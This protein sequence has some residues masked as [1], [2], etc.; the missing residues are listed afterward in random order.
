MKLSLFTIGLILSSS[1]FAQKNQGVVIY[2]RKQNMHRSVIEE[3]RAMIP[4]FRS[5]KHML[6][7]TEQHSLYKI[8]PK[9]EAPDPFNNRSGMAINLGGGTSETYLNFG[10][11]KKLTATDLFGNAYLI[12]DTIRKYDWKL[13]DETKTIAG[14]VCKKATTNYKAFRSVARIMNPLSN[15]SPEPPK[16]EDMLVIAWYALELSSPAGPEN[17]SGL[18]GVIME[19][20]FDNGA[21]VFLAEE[22][23]KLDNISQ[24]KEPKKGRKVTQDEYVIETKKVIE[25]MRNGPIQIKSG[26]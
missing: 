20:D 18:P 5:S 25:N 6:L 16:Q 23:R 13:T 22:Y 26:N 21:T 4:E 2:E 3:M 10:Q 14:Y 9:D 19:L 1:L 11:N 12:Q 8:M 15:V 17:Y 7:F 24:L